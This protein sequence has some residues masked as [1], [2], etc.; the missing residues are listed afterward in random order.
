MSEVALLILDE[1]QH[2]K[3]KHPANLI[4]QQFGT[5]R[6]LRPGHASSA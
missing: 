2:C 1:C 3:R 4:M 6:P 5:Q